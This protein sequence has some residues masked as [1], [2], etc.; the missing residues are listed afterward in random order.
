MYSVIVIGGGISGLAAAWQ[1]RSEAEVTVVEARPRLGGV[2][3]TG[4]V[5]GIDVD[6]GAEAMSALHPDAVEL[7][8]AVGLG[9]DLMSPVPAP[10][11]VW[12]RGALRKLPPGH[13]MGVPA[14]PAAL[15][16]TGL[17]SSEGLE[18]LAREETVPAPPVDGDVAVGR[19]LADRLGQ[20]AV[21]RLVEP[22]LGGV[23]AGRADRLSL[24]AAVPR[25]ARI[26]ESGGSLFAALR[27]EETTTPVFNGMPRVPMCGLRGGLGRLPVAVAAASGA[28]VLTNA[29]VREL[30][31]V[32]RG[33]RVTMSGPGPRTLEADAVVL[34]VPAYAAAGLLR[35][36]APAAG[37]ELGAIAYASTAVVTLAF[38]RA[39]MAA[40]PRGNGFVVP[41]VEGRAV[42]AVT[43]LSNKWS[44]QAAGSP[45]TF[46]VRASLGRFGE[47]RVLGREDGELAAVCLAELGEMVGPLGRPVDFHVSRWARA[48]PQYTVG[49]TDRVRRIRAAVADLHGLELC[50]AAYEG[51]G[52]AACVA[53]GQE[54]ARRV[55]KSAG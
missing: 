25:L 24:R 28:R 10:T 23:Y 21:D 15:E 55:L 53:D 54:A 36:H 43:F 1:L 6:E 40:F 41:P 13:I 20:E 47:E 12:S 22:L 52:V 38:D 5:A 46:L 42:K 31:R 45:G 35:D 48:L 34:A 14:R 11:S 44:R 29:R 7:A 27:E 30:Q 33:W 9:D 37:R 17:L 19:Y 50:G 3:R 32:P 39:G 8:K 49:H 51:V 4:S 18:R 2:L 16:G 26:A